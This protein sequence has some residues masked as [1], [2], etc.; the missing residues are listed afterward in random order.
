MKCLLRF[1]DRANRKN[2]RLDPQEV[3]FLNPNSLVFI[4]DKFFLLPL[5]D[6]ARMEKLRLS[7][8]VTA[9]PTLQDR[10]FEDSLTQ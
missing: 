8:N 10:E 9:D 1:T 2:L 7:V 4:D 3:A 5:P 6:I